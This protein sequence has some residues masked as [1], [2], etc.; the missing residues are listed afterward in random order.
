MLYYYHRA[1]V[2]RGYEEA[3]AISTSLNSCNRYPRFEGDTQPGLTSFASIPAPITCCQR[4]LPILLRRAAISRLWDTRRTRARCRPLPPS[5]V[6][7]FS[8]IL[9]VR[10]RSWKKERKIE[11]ERR[12]FESRDYPPIF[13]KDKM[14][15]SGKGGKLVDSLVLL[16]FFFG[17]KGSRLDPFDRDGELKRYILRIPVKIFEIS[18]HENGDAST[19]ALIKNV[20]LLIELYSPHKHHVLLV[21]RW[22]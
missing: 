14:S 3:I 17:Q 7:L 18:S 16:L 20:L 10:N 15:N 4:L 9:S 2:R 6:F 12:I 22:R 8:P 1:A 19:W 11:F 21:P 13:S 5:D